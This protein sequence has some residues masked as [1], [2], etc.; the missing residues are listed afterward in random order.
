[1]GIPAELVVFGKQDDPLQ[2]EVT[3]FFLLFHCTLL[4]IAQDTFHPPLWV[5]T[6]NQR[7]WE[8]SLAVILLQH[9]SKQSNTEKGQKTCRLGSS[10]LEWWQQQRG[11]MKAG[12]GGRDGK[13]AMMCAGAHPL[14]VQ[15]RDSFQLDLEMHCNL[16]NMCVSVAKAL[17]N[18]EFSYFL[19]V[20]RN[21]KT[22]EERRGRNTCWF[23][24]K[25]WGNMLCMDE[26]FYLF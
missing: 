17:G 13:G 24:C 10:P 8:L 22:I 14:S 2:P 5:K 26:A 4:N 9:S 3:G 11:Q 23:L 1:M 6:R 19:E 7:S 15:K 20:V 25:M 18:S 12:W 21:R 16:V